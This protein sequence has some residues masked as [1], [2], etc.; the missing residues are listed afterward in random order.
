MKKLV[1]IPLYT[2]GTIL[3][4]LLLAALLH[5]F[6]LGPSIRT[7]VT[8]IAP[9]VTKTPVTLESVSVNLFTGNISLKGLVIGN[10]DGFKTEAAMKV[11]E[12]KLSVE[13]M[14]VFSNS[15]HVKQVYVDGAEAWYEAGIPDSNVGKLQK[16]IDDFIGAG[17][18]TA[19]P[20]EKKP[21][22]EGK[23][24]VIDDLQIVNTK[25]HLSVKGIGG[26]ALPVPMPDIKQKD[27]GKEG[28]GKSVA[29]AA[30]DIL[31]SVTGSISEVGAKAVGAITDGAKAIGGAAT[32]VGK[33]AVDA[34]KSAIGAVKG[35]FGGG[36]AKKP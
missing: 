15:I 36:D 31:K 20:E 23:K 8:T 19:K 21:A 25:V 26:A 34:G 11:G 32:D 16:N 1:K 29:Q 24:V 27:I 6:F 7:A 33:G 28:D 35:L 30:A 5:P 12:V 4:L 13:P 17:G 10:P 14:S 9:M 22:G 18:K 3:V 2:I